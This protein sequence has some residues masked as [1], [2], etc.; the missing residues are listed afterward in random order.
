M[1][2]CHVLP[3][4]HRLLLYCFFLLPDVIAVANFCQLLTLDDAVDLVYAVAVLLN[5]GGKVVVVLD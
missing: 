2:Q 5:Y 4:I 3:F 1:C